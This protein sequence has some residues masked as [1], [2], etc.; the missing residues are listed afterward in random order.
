M[1]KLEG[2]K[3]VSNVGDG[4]TTACLMSARALLDGRPFS[5]SH[6]SAV[7]R[8]IGIRINDGAWWDSDEERTRVLLPLALD[9]RLCADNCN[10]SRETEAKRAS[11]CAVWALSWAAPFALDQAALVLESCWPDHAHALRDHATK[12][13]AEPTRANALAAAY[14]AYAAYAAA[15]APEAYAAYV[16]YAA[17]YAADAAGR[18]A[19]VAYAAAY[20]A[21]AAYDAAGRAADAKCSHMAAKKQVRDSLIDLFKSLLDVCVQS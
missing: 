6:P 7:L 2:I 13:R 17:A 21:D 14:A 5:D 18:A 20:A 15:C 8:K 3:F 9:A 12:L 10:A 11:L 1:E 19:D 4:R 16:A